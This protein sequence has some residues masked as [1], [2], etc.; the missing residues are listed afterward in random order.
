MNNPR[1]SF[2]GQEE[3]I[4]PQLVVYPA[5]IRE[6]LKK[7]I[8]HAGGA[9]RLWPHLKTHKMEA[10]LRIHMELGISRFKCA[11]IAEAEM[12]AA[13]G[14]TGPADMGKLMGA[15]KPKLAG[16]AD[17]GLVSKLVKQKLAG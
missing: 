5:I 15:L 10:V 3:L 8:A 9:H 4:S 7:M 6:N 14:A 17:M 13:T 1:Y 2:E 11:T 16:K 12:A